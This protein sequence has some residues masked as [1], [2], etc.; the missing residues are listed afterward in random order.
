M[1]A[2]ISLEVKLAYVKIAWVLVYVRKK[3]LEI[4]TS[5]FDLM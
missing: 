5:Y 1:A 2:V 4:T 3:D